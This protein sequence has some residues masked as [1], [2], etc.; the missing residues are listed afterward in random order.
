MTTFFSFCKGMYSWSTDKYGE[1][2]ESV[3][4]H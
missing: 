4:V 2:C 3:R 1:Y